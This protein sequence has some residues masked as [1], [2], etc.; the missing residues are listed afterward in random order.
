MRRF[1]QHDNLPRGARE[2]QKRTTVRAVQMDEEFEVE[3][4]E[5]VM[6]GKMGDYLA[7]GVKG[8]LYPIDKEIFELSHVEFIEE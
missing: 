4:M 8:E 1:E 5:G 6:K 3:T 2:Y 7:E